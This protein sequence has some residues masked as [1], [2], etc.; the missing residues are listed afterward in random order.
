[1][2][3]A[4]SPFNWKQANIFDLKLWAKSP[5]A[6]GHNFLNYIITAFRVWM[7]GND[8]KSRKT[9]GHTCLEMLNRTSTDVIEVLATRCI[10]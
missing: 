6:H 5:L 8:R 3:Y 7:L 1:M 4:V 2:L 9:Q 10:S